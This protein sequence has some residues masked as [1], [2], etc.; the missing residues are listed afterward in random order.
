MKDQ[1]WLITLDYNNL[2]LKDLRKLYQLRDKTKCIN[3]ISVDTN[4][5]P[6]QNK[7]K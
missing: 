3:E 7:N 2:A 6:Q 5:L 4:T 1:S